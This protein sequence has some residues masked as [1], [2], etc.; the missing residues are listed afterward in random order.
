MA[1]RR[2]VL[3]TPSLPD[4]RRSPRS[5]SRFRRGSV[6]RNRRAA[7]RK[8]MRESGVRELAWC[9]LQSVHAPEQGRCQRDVRTERAL[10]DAIVKRRAHSAFAGDSRGISSRGDRSRSGARR[11]RQVEAHAPSSDTCSSAGPV[12]PA[13]TTCATS[14][15]FMKKPTTG[16]PDARCVSRCAGPERDL[17]AE[18]LRPREAAAQ[19]RPRRR[20]D[21]VEPPR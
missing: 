1:W 15:C 4:E 19:L 13:R 3:S 20:L 11:T 18:L 12:L 14:I 21:L 16:Q 9:V 17:H 2:W 6:R 7:A 5:Q 10:I 8:R